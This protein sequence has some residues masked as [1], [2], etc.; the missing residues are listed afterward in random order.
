MK[1]ERLFLSI[2]IFFVLLISVGCSDGKSTP[3]APSPIPTSTPTPPPGNARSITF[4]STS[5]PCGSQLDSTK[6]PV[7]VV[8]VY[9]V[10]TE[11]SALEIGFLSTNGTRV[12]PRVGVPF[13]QKGRGYIEV[14]INFN[15]AKINASTKT[16]R[17][18]IISGWNGLVAVLAQDIVDCPFV[19]VG[20]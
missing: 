2:V 11:D 19:F 12:H 17:V 7:I 4:I 1:R 6:N 15:G 5:S 10:A 3:T 14:P 8:K 13:V 9:Y 18:E 16:I 20:Q